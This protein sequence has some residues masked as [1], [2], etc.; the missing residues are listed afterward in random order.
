MTTF[1]EFLQINEMSP[2]QLEPRELPYLMTKMPFYSNDTLK[3]E[4][5]ILSNQA[6]SARGKIIIAIKKDKTFAVIGKVARRPKDKKLGMYI[7]GRLEF[8]K[9]IDIGDSVPTLVQNNMKKV[10]QVDGVEIIK[11][12]KRQGYGYLLYFNLIKS[13]FILI[14]DNV[15]YLGGQELWKKIAREAKFDKYKVYI[16]DN[17]IFRKKDNEKVFYDG[18][19]IKESELWSNQYEKYHTLFVAIR[20]E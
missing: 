17:G 14:S 10:L 6:I 11:E 19:N 15:Q 12:L 3:D 9:P 5:D 20:D 4:F 13:G 16:L 1:R 2:P 7:Y 8:K 18:S